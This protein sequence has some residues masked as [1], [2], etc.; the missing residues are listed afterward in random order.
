[1]LPASYYSRHSSHWILL[2]AELPLTLYPLTRGASLQ[3][4]PVPLPALWS[5]N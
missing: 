2:A 5:G 3:R 1:M 4:A